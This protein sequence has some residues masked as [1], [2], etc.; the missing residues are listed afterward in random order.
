[1]FFFILM[2][3]SISFFFSSFSAYLDKA[4]KMGQPMTD[5]GLV[6]LVLDDFLLKILFKVHEIILG[7]HHFFV[8]AIYCLALSRPYMN[9]SIF[10]LLFCFSFCS[11]LFFS[12]N[13]SYRCETFFFTF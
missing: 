11:L 4:I 5:V 9:R 8:I 13:I 6:V 2:K 3:R 10:L 1:M 12:N 7:G